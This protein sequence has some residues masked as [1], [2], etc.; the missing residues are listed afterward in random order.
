[1]NAMVLT[2]VKLSTAWWCVENGRAIEAKRLIMGVDIP[3][4]VIGSP[5]H[6]RNAMTALSELWRG[7][8]PPDCTWS[9]VGEL[10][11]ER[12][13]FSIEEHEQCMTF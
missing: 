8:F 7:R 5:V 1:M 11:P 10:F 12:F 9:S 6:H 13:F 2:Y 4:L 3:R